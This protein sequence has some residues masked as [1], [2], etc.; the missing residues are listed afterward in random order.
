M[1][2]V[3]K[4]YKVLGTFFATEFVCLVVIRNELYRRYHDCSPGTMPSGQE[5][6]QLCNLRSGADFKLHLYKTGILK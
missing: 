6:R 2:K 3:S 1:T 5:I 4:T